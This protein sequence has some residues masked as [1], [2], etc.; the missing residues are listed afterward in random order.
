MSRGHK[1]VRATIERQPIGDRGGLHKQFYNLRSGK[2]VHRVTDETK[3]PSLLLPLSAK[4]ISGSFCDSRA[5]VGCCF[6]VETFS[7]PYTVFWRKVSLW[8][9]LLLF[10]LFVLFFLFGQRRLT[11]KARREVSCWPFLLTLLGAYS[12]W[13]LLQYPLE[14]TKLLLFLAWESCSLSMVLYLHWPSITREWLWTSQYKESMERIGETSFLFTGALSY[15]SHDVRQLLFMK[16]TLVDSR[17]AP[18]TA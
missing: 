4:R 5:C 18:S 1:T 10:V 14:D 15:R 16:R 6:L 3:S 11:G 9:I 8:T 12:Y 17:S 2:K 7:K 13:V